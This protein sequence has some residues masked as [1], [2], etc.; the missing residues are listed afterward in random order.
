[1]HRQQW[2]VSPVGILAIALTLAWGATASA[3]APSFT[4]EERGFWS[5]QPIKRPATPN[6]NDKSWVQTPVDAFVLARLESKGLAPAPRAD[7]VKLIRRA[8][9][10]LHGLPPTPAEVEAFVNDKSDNAFERL[11]DRLLASP[12]YGERMARLWLDLVRYADSD[13]FK[14]D[15]YRPLAWRYRDYVVRAFNS[16]KPYD[17]FVLEQLAGDELAPNDPDA[18]IATGYLRLWPYEFNQRNVKKQWDEIIT[19]VTKVTGEVFIGMSVGCAQCHDHKFDPI[20][21]E[22]HYRLRAFLGTILPDDSLTAATPTQRESYESQ[23]E[24]YNR[25]T[26]ELRQR[27]R[28][29]M[30]PH[31]QAVERSAYSKFTDDIK[32]VL[33]GKWD[34]LTPYER[35]IADLARRQMIYEH[36]KIEG[37]IKGKEKEQVDQLRKALA[38]Y[39]TMKPEQLTPIMA[40]RDA[41]ERGPV[42]TIPGD[43]K[44]RNIEPGYLSV[45]DPNPVTI[46]KPENNPNSSGRRLTL[47]RWITSAENPLASRVA[48]NRI[49]QQHF[50]RGIVGTPND[51]GTLGERPTH[52]QLLDWLATEFI[53]QEWSFKRMHK[54]MMMSSAYQQESVVAASDAAAQADPQNKLLWRQRVRRLDGEQL[55]DAMLVSAGRLDVRMGGQ[56]VDETSTRRSIYVKQMRNNRPRMIETFDGPDMHN[57]CAQRNT[58]TTAPQA[59]MLINGKWSMDMAK[60]MAARLRKQTDGSASK[61]IERAYRWALGRRPTEAEVN[62]ALAFVKAYKTLPAPTP[63]GDLSADPVLRKV[64]AADMDLRQGDRL[65][66]K[67]GPDLKFESFTIETR[68]VLRSL[69][70]DASVRVLVA[71]WDGSTSR[72]GW[73]FGVTSTRSKYQPRNLIFQFVGKD[74][75]GKTTYEVVAS[76]LRPQLNRLYQAVATVN[77]KDSGKTGITFVLR[78]LSDPTSKPQAVQVEHRVVSGIDTSADLTIGNR[79]AGGKQHGWDGLIDSVR[80]YNAAHPYE[81]VQSGQAARDTLVGE[82]LFDDAKRLTADTCGRERHLSND[83]VTAWSA[84]QPTRQHAGEVSEKALADFCHVLLNSNEFLYVD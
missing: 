44:Q 8:T 76:N 74:K 83:G 24:E 47:A 3:D 7:R 29:I 22:D 80:L 52:P 72:P 35:Q 39:D 30:S 71:Q 18:M 15:H 26:A 40:I 23:T 43:R 1:M 2:T 78:D 67:D 63:K 51:F 4:A 21:Q 19:D 54:L 62:D 73:S 14:A 27:M 32:T 53:R 17:R 9:F 6:V 33:D 45:I 11:I 61:T 36:S 75:A 77:L 5:Y 48:V 70:A 56:G 25:A 10:D 46:R 49:W 84:D 68:F 41:G 59:L 81:A 38:E 20:T 64:A 79:G 82:W 69:A 58:T 28:K 37:R 65:S 50:G 34:D 60:A 13:G 16:D 55:R 12:R 66:L 57:S 42:V 31:R